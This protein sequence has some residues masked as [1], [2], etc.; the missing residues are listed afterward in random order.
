[1]LVQNKYNSRPLLTGMTNVLSVIETRY[2][3][4]P[5]PGPLPEG[6]GNKVSLRECY[7]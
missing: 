1:M 7:N 5:L 4:F 3:R 6:E 2:A